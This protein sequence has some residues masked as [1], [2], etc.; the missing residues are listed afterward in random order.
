MDNTLLEFILFTLR[1]HFPYDIDIP[2][3]EALYDFFHGEYHFLVFT[4]SPMRVTSH[5]IAN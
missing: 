2:Q 5:Q 4:C 1:V 3:S